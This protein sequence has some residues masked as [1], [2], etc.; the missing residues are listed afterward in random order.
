MSNNRR[1]FSLKWQFTLGLGLL[2]ITLYSVYS[3]Y[4]YREA[5]DNFSAGRAVAQENQINIARA[6]TDESFFVLER[7]IESIALLQE[8]KTSHAQL[9]N[10]FDQ[11]WSQW[12]MIWGLRNVVLYKPNGEQI[13]NWGSEFYVSKDEIVAMV[14]KEH[15]LRKIVCVQG[16]YQQV[17]IPVLSN[18][19]IIAVLG[20]SLSLA[21]TLLNYQNTLHS[22]IGVIVKDEDQVFSMM[23]HAT[24]NN[25]LWKQVQALYDIEMLKQSALVFKSGKKHYELPTRQL[26]G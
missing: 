5:T 12:Q 18:H 2:L 23:T 15:P 19:K 14:N 26:R 6:L 7:F 11:Y 17:L 4:V 3:Y 13:K 25:K 1:L 9:I 20:I 22:D 16:C 8:N 10:L 24:L 21:D